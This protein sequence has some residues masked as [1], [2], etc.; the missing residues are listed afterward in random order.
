MQTGYAG[1]TLI[2]NLGV[3]NSLLNPKIRREE[4]MGEH[5]AKVGTKF[6]RLTAMIEPGSESVRGAIFVS[7]LS[8]LPEYAAI[9]ASSNT[10]KNHVRWN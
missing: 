6:S 1:K 4:Q 10:I 2:N 5:I 8:N 9:T 3:V 7:S